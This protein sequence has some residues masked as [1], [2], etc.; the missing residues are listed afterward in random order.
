MTSL[1][2]YNGSTCRPHF[3]N[4][5][6]TES[7]VQPPQVIR[8]SLNEQNRT[9]SESRKGIKQH[10]SSWIGLRVQDYVKAMQFKVVVPMA[11]PIRVLCR[12]FF[13]QNPIEDDRY[14]LF[15]N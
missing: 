15:R 10:A 12:S 4:S 13:V 3:V 9:K 11:L 2:H 14:T 5:T 8:E 6:T 7:T 1:S